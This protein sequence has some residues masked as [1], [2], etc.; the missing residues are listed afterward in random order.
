MLAGLRG[1]GRGSTKVKVIGMIPGYYPMLPITQV[2]LLPPFSG[3][4][5]LAARQYRL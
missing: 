4:R 2:D 3:I 5:L 1:V